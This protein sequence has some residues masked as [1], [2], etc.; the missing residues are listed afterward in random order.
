MAFRDIAARALA[1]LER[2]T[3]TARQAPRIVMEG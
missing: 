3:G 1:E 2:S